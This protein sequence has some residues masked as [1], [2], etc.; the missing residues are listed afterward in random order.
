MDFLQKQRGRV[1]HCQLIGGEVSLLPAADHARALEVMRFY[2]RIPMSFTHGD[3]SYDYLKALALDD[4]GKPRF[5]RLD[6]AVHFDMFMYGRTGIRRPE[7]E[8]ALHEY[9]ARFVEMFRHLE[10]EHGVRSY[11][12]HNVTVQEGNFDQIAD[13]VRE[14]RTYGFRMLSFQ[15]AAA[16]GH[17]RAPRLARDDGEGLWAQIEKGAGTALPTSLFQMGDPRCNRVS[18]CAVVGDG[19]K[20]RVVPLF[21][22]AS[23]G[24]Q[25]LRDAL[26]ERFGNIALPHAILWLKGLRVLLRR[27]WLLFLAFSWFF[28][29]ARRCGDLRD[30]LF[31]RCRLITF[32][33]HRFM[34]ADDVRKAWALMEAGHDETDEAVVSAGPR[35]LET[36]ERLRAC[37]YGMAQVEQGRIVPACVQHSV[38]DADENKQLA[39]LL[40][41]EGKERAAMPPADEISLQ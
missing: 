2:G 15:P 25:R 10:R 27:P 39:Q 20:A 30:V 37:S 28:R 9:R 5:R 7:S 16:T 18:F 29:F 23:A 14:L 34:D 11:L 4:D 36:V 35:V 32:V 3:F 22:A 41:T 40:R 26:M 8:A 13:V 19:E 6:F 21:D 33:M 31:G 38:F 1:A 24:D 12:A 17:R